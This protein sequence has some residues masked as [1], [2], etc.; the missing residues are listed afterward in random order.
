MTTTRETILKAIWHGVDP[1]APQ[2]V[3]ERETDFQGWGS[4]HP[5]LARAVHEVRPTVVLEMGVWK[6]GSVITLAEELKVLQLDAVVIAVDTWLGSSEH[7]TR[8]RY[9]GDL[10]IEAGY[11]TIYRTFAA[12]IRA[13]GLENYVVP[14]PLDS[15]SA[16]ELIAEKNI[17]VDV[18]HI[19][20][21]HSYESVL[22]DLRV[23]WPVLRPGG[24]LIGDDYHPTGSPHWPG[25]RRA[26]HEFFD[27][28]E[29]ENVPTKCYVRKPPAA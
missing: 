14:L 7:R 4:A 5:Y 20:G 23:W 2:S 1:F 12:N 10:K 8:G 27:T 6:G 22:A 15:L 11:P 26:F 13:K 28:T 19:D 18:L 25:V 3:V 21:G 29:I 9:F 24:I 17:A 16:A